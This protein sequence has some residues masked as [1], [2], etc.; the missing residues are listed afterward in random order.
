[1]NRNDY[2]YK[3]IYPD[4]FNY[5]AGVQTMS[6]LPTVNRKICTPAIKTAGEDGAVKLFV[7]GL[8]ADPKKSY[9]HLISVGATEFYGPNLRGDA[10]NET[11]GDFIPPDPSEGNKV[12]ELEGGLD[13]FHNPT[14]RS[15]GSVYS[16]HKSV[17][18][19]GEPQG[20]VAF[21]TY[22]KP[23]HRGELII[24]VPND[25]W[26]T[27][28]EKIENGNPVFFSMGCLCKN[29]VCSICGKRTSPKD[30]ESRCDHLKDNLL[31]FDNK[32]NQVKAITDHPI[33]FDISQVARPAD[34]I[35]FSLAKVASADIVLPNTMP[36][37]LLDKLTGK[38][39]VDR[40]ALAFKVAKEEKVSAE[41]LPVEMPDAEDHDVINKIKSDDVPRVLC[42]LKRNNTMLPPPVFFKLMGKDSFDEI[43]PVMPLIGEELGSIF[44]K[45]VNSAELPD[46]INNSTYEGSQS[47]FD[48]QLEQDL[49]PLIRKYSLD[50]QPVK[51]RIIK[52]T[53]S[54]KQ[55]SE[56][57]KIIT[58]LAQKIASELA[59]EY[60]RYQLAFIC[61]HDDS[62]S[63]RLTLANNHANILV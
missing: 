32:G 19:G 52:I 38:S 28:I 31:G 22:N 4:E 61:K 20:K 29:D 23:M 62:R 63:I 21:A 30:L 58:P 11:A 26:G 46:F 44:N 14:F 54:K 36:I 55:A 24:E 1:M 56:P 35:A 25:T 47:I 6:I 51:N 33:F 27:E 18:V 2:N 41:K 49:M 50:D 8:E 10:F 16:E 59:R 45:V 42:V 12:V 17:L 37:N 15:N 34:R 13:E 7:D 57:L 39:A 40:M 5:E 60:A 53:I 9:I 3:L 43:K 48:P